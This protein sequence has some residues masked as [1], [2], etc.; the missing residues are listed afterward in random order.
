MDPSLGRL[1]FFIMFP[2]IFRAFCLVVKR[3]FVYLQAKW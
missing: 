3:K 2:A 1:S